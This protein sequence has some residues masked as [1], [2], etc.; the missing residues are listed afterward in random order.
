M[1]NS[2][3]VMIDDAYCFFMKDAKAKYYEKNAKYYEKHPR[4]R[5]MPEELRGV[6]MQKWRD[7]SDADKAPYV[8]CAEEL[9]AQ[10]LTYLTAVNDEQEVYYKA[11]FGTTKKIAKSGKT[12]KVADKKDSKAK[13]CEKQS[14]RE[15]MS[16]DLGEAIMQEWMDMSDADKAPYVERAEELRAQGL[17][18]LD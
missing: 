18:Y 3:L 1:H 15:I 5:I 11:K 13:Y 17:T 7:M 2:C 8:E 10:G 9:R 16:E 4:G 12:K 6:I 14:Q